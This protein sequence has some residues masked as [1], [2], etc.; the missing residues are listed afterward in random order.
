MAF[1]FISLAMQAQDNIAI[2][3]KTNRYNTY[4]AENMVQ[5]SLLASPAAEAVDVQVDFGFG[6][7]E[8]TISSEGTILEDD[9]LGT[10]VGGTTISG[11]VSKSGVVKVYCD[12]QAHRAGHTLSS[13][14]RDK[15]AGPQHT[16]RSGIS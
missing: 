16:W 10:F 6:K 7:Q 13:T 5:F 2:T 11:R 14:Q 1:F 8:Y 15:E 12:H 9:S 4:G 3:M